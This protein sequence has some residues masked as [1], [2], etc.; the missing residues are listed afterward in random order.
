VQIGLLGDLRAQRIDD[1]Q[2]AAL[3]HRGA[4][5]AHQMQ[6]GDRRIVAPHDVERGVLRRLRSD[7][8]YRTIGARPGLAAYPAAQGPAI[9]L[10]G[11]EPMEE[12]QRHAVHRQHAVRARI[13][14]RYHR[15]WAE[16]L[17]HLRH[18]SMDLVERFIPANPLEPARAARP[19][20]PQRPMQP[21]GAV[22]ELGAVTPHLVADDPAR[23][24]QRV[25]AAHLY[26]AVPLHLHGEAAGIRTI[27]GTDTGAFQD[28]HDRLQKR[29]R[30]FCRC[31]RICKRANFH[32]TIR[33]VCRDRL[34]A[35]ERSR[36][37]IYGRCAHRA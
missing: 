35:L 27:E 17:D 32:L 18:A 26:D 25:R 9:E 13:V 6:I 15:L 14:E 3:S 16:A 24:R 8:G 22:C 4:D 30:A 21:V 5:V 33:P 31:G 20:A 19:G 28:R 10:A 7:A 36:L 2:P 11:A 23:V 12:A 1:G 29:G 34:C 37:R